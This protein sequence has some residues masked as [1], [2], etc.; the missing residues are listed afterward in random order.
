M[1]GGADTGK[2]RLLAPPQPSA[3]KEPEQPKGSG[4]SK[5]C[6]AC[7][8]A[9]GP[10]SGARSAPHPQRRPFV[11]KCSSSGGGSCEA[12]PLHAREVLCREPA[13]L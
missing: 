12:G 11:T 2:G 7:A 6:S 8:S 4:L 5:P 13:V 10:Q 9:P 1:T 3:S